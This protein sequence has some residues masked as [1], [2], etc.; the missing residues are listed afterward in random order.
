[1]KLSV[2]SDYAMRAVFGLA[3]HFG[4]GHAIRVEKL[5]KEQGIPPNY[6]V[7]ILIELKK[8]G[9]VTSTR[10]K[11][12]GYKLARDPGDISAGDVIRCIHGSIFESPHNED[13]PPHPAIT[14]VWSKLQSNLDHSADAISFQNLIQSSQNNQE[15]YYI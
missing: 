4:S 5:A 8:G 6:L 10:G 13:N 1:M 15:M 14:S 3:L 2:K 11:E 12:G 9:L 7:Q